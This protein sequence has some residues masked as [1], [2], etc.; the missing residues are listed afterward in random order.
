MLQ[1]EDPPTTEIDRARVIGLSRSSLR[2]VR[3]PR[4]SNPRAEEWKTMVT[5]MSGMLH[6]QSDFHGASATE[7]ISNP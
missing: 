2:R 6:S 4:L 1:S 5:T 3:N 7:V